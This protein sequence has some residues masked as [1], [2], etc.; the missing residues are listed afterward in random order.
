[1]LIE[2]IENVTLGPSCIDYDPPRLNFEKIE[3]QRDDFPLQILGVNGSGK[4][5]L[6]L[7]LAGAIPNAFWAQLALKCV[8]RTD[9]KEYN[10]PDAQNLL[11]VIPQRWQHGLLG[12]S[13]IEEIALALKSDSTWGRHV[14]SKLRINQLDKW[15]PFSLSEGE[16]KRLMIGCALVSNVPLLISDEWTIHLDPYWINQIA[17]LFDEYQNLRGGLHLDLVSS[18]QMNSNGNIIP[19]ITQISQNTKT[20]IYSGSIN[21]KLN[22]NLISVLTDECL[23]FR[24]TTWPRGLYL[25]AT[26]QY[27]HKKKYKMRLVGSGK[28]M[29][30][31]IGPN[32]SGKTTLLRNLWRLSHHPLRNAFYRKQKVPFVYLVTADP[33]YQVL[34]P[35][36]ADEFSRVVYRKSANAPKMLGEQFCSIIGTTL[37]SDVLNL[38][39]GQRKM[40][41]LI[42]ACVG[43]FPLIA[44]DEPF[45]GLDETNLDI[46]KTIL[47]I[48]VRCGKLVIVTNQAPTVEKIGVNVKRV[49]LEK[50]HD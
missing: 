1:M 18:K 9:K 10:F 41:A 8:I 32:G 36:V 43:P 26:I 40:L 11:R 35:T 5:S 15:H 17:E 23:R 44:F 34:G 39:F 13:A 19:L 50:M 37:D 48:A 30:E 7:A 20:T 28:E 45:V 22:D 29:I 4:T 47:T 24:E 33:L 16:K 38:S 3:L 27:Q 12:Y 49:V 46:A 42:I 21:E 25:D 31:I 2:R 6:V 14:C